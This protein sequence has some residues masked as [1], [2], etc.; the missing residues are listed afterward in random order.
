MFGELGYDCQ[1]KC[2]IIIPSVNGPVDGFG[3][4][5]DINIIGITIPSII[6]LICYFKIWLQWRQNTKNLKTFGTNHK[7]SNEDVRL[8]F[9]M[10]LICISFMTFSS[11]LII[12]EVVLR[13]NNGSSMA[14]LCLFWLQF[15]SNFVIYAIC[16]KQY[17]SAFVYFLQNV[18]FCNKLCAYTHLN[19]KSIEVNVIAKK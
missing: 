2:C 10:L 9:S 3:P 18:V 17:R 16:N 19:S 13:T 4:N 6:I 7:N 1:K 8:G 15:Y 5:N 11:L 14:F 12:Y